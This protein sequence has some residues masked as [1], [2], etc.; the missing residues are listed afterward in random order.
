MKKKKLFIA[1]DTNCIHTA[2]YE[3]EAD[4]LDDAIEVFCKEQF[5]GAVKFKNNGWRWGKS[6]YKSA[7]ELLAS[8][9]DLSFEILDKSKTYSFG[10]TKELFC[11]IDKLDYFYSWNSKDF[12][13]HNKTK[14]GNCYEWTSE[15]KVYFIIMKSPKEVIKR[16]NKMF[17]AI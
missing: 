1:L 3:I 9:V 17:K 6:Y 14:I 15:D 4:N 7:K 16:L 5:S 2:I 8:S 13:M 10:K 12:Y 11:G